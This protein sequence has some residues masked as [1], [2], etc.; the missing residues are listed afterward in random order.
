[1]KQEVKS[2]NVGECGSNI[3]W[4][5][6]ELKELGDV[7]RID[8]V[9]SPTNEEAIERTEHGTIYSYVE[10]HDSLRFTGYENRLIKIWLFKPILMMRYPFSYGDSIQG[11]TQ[12]VGKY[13]ENLTISELGRYTVKADAKGMMVIPNGDTL[14]NVMRIHTNILLSSKS[15]PDNE[16]PF[17]K[18]YDVLSD[19]DVNDKIANDSNIIELNIYQWYAKGYRYPVF[20]TRMYGNGS[21]ESFYYPIE[22]Q[23]GMYDKENEDVRKEESEKSI[24]NNDG[25]KGIDNQ[26]LEYCITETS[27]DRFEVECKPNKPMD[28]ECNLCT[29]D[30]M[31]I[32][33][34]KS[35]SDGVEPQKFTINLSGLRH[36]VYAI[37]I[38]AMGKTYSRQ[39]TKK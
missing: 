23:E 2:M 5:Y 33:H 9:A 1:M 32:V 24:I 31:L 34:K 38:K 15:T 21:A 30:G 35:H 29:V 25:N 16:N 18:H 36:G 19:K 10:K 7:Q 12:G 22:E 28:I 37:N 20:E 14:R 4:D 8:Y 17:V 3:V 6:S 26:N 39:I 11:C 27:T 13:C